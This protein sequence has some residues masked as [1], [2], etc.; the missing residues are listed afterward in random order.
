MEWFNDLWKRHMEWS[1]GQA[2]LFISIQTA[3]S[4]NGYLSINLAYIGVLSIDG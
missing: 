2:I 1:L 4:T 3:T